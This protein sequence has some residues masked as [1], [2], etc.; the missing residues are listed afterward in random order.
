[1]L[2]WDPVNHYKEVAVAER[3]DRIRFNSI[4]GKAFNAIEKSAIKSAFRDIKRGT[5]VLD[6][7]CGT[8]RLAEALLDSGLRVEGADIS[9]AMQSPTATASPCN[10][11]L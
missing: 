2:D 4:S 8:G 11:W 1:M 3:Y 7:P 5:Q 6:V 9:A 10:H